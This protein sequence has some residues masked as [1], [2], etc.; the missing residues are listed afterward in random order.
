M[1]ECTQVA[2]REFP[3]MF[4]CHIPGHDDG[5]MMGQCVTT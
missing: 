3:F 4:H 2:T 1:Q 5:G